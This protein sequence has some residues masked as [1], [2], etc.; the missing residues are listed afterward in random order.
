MRLEAH[1]ANCFSS[2]Y[3]LKLDGR[4]AGTIRNRWLSFG[5]DIQFT[6]RLRLYFERTFSLRKATSWLVGGGFQLADADADAKEVL[7]TG[8]RTGLL[9]GSWNLNLGVGP[10]K[11]VQTSLFSSDFVVQKGSQVIARASRISWC[12]ASWQAEGSDALNVTDLVFIGLVYHA[13]LQR[14]GRSP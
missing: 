14:Q 3:L 10:T 2:K 7:A 13:I 11:L 1:S 9:T 4:P 6:E 12:E 5:I 8:Q